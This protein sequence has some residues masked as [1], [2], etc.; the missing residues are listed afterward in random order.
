MTLQRILSIRVTVVPL[1]V[2][3]KHFFLTFICENDEIRTFIPHSNA[4]FVQ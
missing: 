1:A 2:I 3:L 4:F